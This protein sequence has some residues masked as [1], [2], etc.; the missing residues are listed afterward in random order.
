MFHRRGLHLQNGIGIE[1]KISYI[2]L[3][4]KSRDDVVN[5]RGC[6][7]RPGREITVFI[8]FKV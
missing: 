1:E 4:L 6:K 2:I 5:H 7:S 8:S 3:S